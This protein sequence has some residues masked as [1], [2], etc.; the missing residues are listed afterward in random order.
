M[1]RFASAVSVFFFNDTATTEIYTLSPTRRSSDLTPASPE[2]ESA[3]PDHER[4]RVVAGELGVVL[5]HGGE[6]VLRS[7]A[8]GVGRVH[9]DDGHASVAGHGGEPVTEPGGWD[10]GCLVP[11]RPAPAS[12]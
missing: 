11:E 1:S 4:C 10:A 5:L 6:P 7:P 8:G 9:R 3:S 2:A 12:P